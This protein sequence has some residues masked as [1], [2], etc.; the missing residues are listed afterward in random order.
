MDLAFLWKNTSSQL[1]ITPLG[2]FDKTWYVQRMS[3]TC[4]CVYSKG[5]PVQLFL[6]EL[7]PL[8]LTFSWKNTLSSLLLNLLRDFDKGRSKC[9]G[10]ILQREYCYHCFNELWPR[11]KKA[12]GRIMYRWRCPVFNKIWKKVRS[13]CVDVHIVKGTLSIYFKRSYGPWT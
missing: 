4:R 2:D 11:V 10:S 6:K 7:W 8:D 13:Q 5:N 3:T 12:C 1:F 9:E